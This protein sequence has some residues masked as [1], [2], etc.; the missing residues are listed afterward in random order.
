MAAQT[1]QLE[2]LNKEVARTQEA[3]DVFYRDSKRAFLS[4]IMAKER[5]AAATTAF[6]DGEKECG[7]FSGNEDPAALAMKMAQAAITEKELVDKLNE[8]DRKA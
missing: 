5:S 7:N 3:Y 2:A 4:R 6:A 8:E 1:A